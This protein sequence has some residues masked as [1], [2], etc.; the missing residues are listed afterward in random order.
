M[1]FG[2]IHIHI[3]K[4]VILE[5]RIILSVRIINL[6]D[7]IIRSVQKICYIIFVKMLKTWKIRSSLYVCT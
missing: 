4:I 5:L 2:I 6:F 1:K 3:L 7:I